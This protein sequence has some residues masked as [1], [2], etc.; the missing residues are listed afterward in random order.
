M[1]NST[2]PR[3]GERTY[4]LKLNYSAIF[5][6]IFKKPIALESFK[7]Q[8]ISLKNRSKTFLE[9]LRSLESR[10]SNLK[11][12]KIDV[13]KYIPEKEDFDEILNFLESLK[14]IKE[15]SLGSLEISSRRFFFDF[16]QTIVK[17]SSCLRILQI[18]EMTKG[19]SRHS[20]IDIVNEVLEKR[21]IEHFGCPVDLDFIQRIETNR[22]EG[23]N[24]DESKRRI[25]SLHK[26]LYNF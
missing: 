7:V 9:L 5:K 21:G 19:M 22:Y 16:I 20:F 24:I 1:M 25:L 13:G 8:I 11:E 17:M 2:V 18:R 6:K 23:P 10:A 12:L 14:K 3:R 26:P 15:L 4:L